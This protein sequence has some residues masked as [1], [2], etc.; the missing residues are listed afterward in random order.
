MVRIGFIVASMLVGVILLVAGVGLFVVG[1]LQPQRT[2]VF[3]FGTLGAFSLIPLGLSL[4]LLG[5]SYLP[6]LA[7]RKFIRVCRRSLGA[8]AKNPGAVRPGDMLR[9]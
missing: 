9:I 5:C 4:L 1:V 3:L 6:F 8:C 7:Y 2:F